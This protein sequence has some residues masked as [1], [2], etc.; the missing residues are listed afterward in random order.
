MKQ[1]KYLEAQLSQYFT[2]AVKLEIT[3]ITVLLKVEE[4]IQV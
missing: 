1:L 4:I 3:S 2:E